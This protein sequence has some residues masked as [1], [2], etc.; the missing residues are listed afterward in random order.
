MLSQTA[1]YALRAVLY[2]AARGEAGAV[3]VEA[4]A[5]ELG[6]PPSYLSKTCQVLVRHGVLESVRGR[7]GGF[8]LA[9]APERL[10]LACVVDPFEDETERRHCLL[11]RATCSDQHACA[12]HASWKATSEQIARYFRTTTVAD[13]QGR[14]R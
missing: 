14:G 4:M 3:G 10:Q 2:L 13:L 8:R 6:I 11:G 9:M 7:S 1:E 5:G 12:A